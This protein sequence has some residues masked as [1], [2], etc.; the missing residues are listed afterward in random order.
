MRDFGCDSERLRAL[1]ENHS[2]VSKLSS[3][4]TLEV[5]FFSIRT[6]R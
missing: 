4:P 3:S 6:V 2:K 1:I 5:Y